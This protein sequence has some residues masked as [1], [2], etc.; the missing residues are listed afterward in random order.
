MKN[1][2]TKIF[3]FILFIIALLMGYNYF[4]RPFL[5]NSQQT[6][7]DEKDK[8]EMQEAINIYVDEKLSIFDQLSPEQKITQIMALPYNVADS[9]LEIEELNSY[10]SRFEAPSQSVDVAPTYEDTPKIKEDDL[11]QFDYRLNAT[12]SSQLK[13]FQ[14]GIITLFGEKVSLTDAKRHLQA[15][16]FEF[17]DQALKPLI[18]VD[19]EGGQVQRLSGEGFKIL[20]AWRLFCTKDQTQRLELLQDSAKQL[21]D[22]GVAIVF[23]PV[24]DLNSQVLGSRSCQDYQQAFDSAQDYISTFGLNGIMPVIKHFPGLGQTKQDLHLSSD[25]VDLAQ[26]DTQIFSKILNEYPN[27][28]IMT[29][30]LQLK[31]KLD[32]LPCSLSSECLSVFP[33]QFPLSLIF[34]DALEMKALDSWAEKLSESFEFLFLEED[35]R[36]T[37]A[38]KLAVLSYYAILAGNNVLVYGDKITIEQLIKVRSELAAHYLQ[39]EVFK[40]KVDLSVIKLLATKKI[41]NE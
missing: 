37:P 6:V 21:S 29:A 18:A 8:K 12:S 30:H 39:D 31:D 26:E 1:N 23:A 10:D 41:N 4:A 28:G 2:S 32:G 34:S 13:Q 17:N 27:I 22:L 33:E 19:H 36:D 20:P 40:K 24:L 9:E 5:R 14:P 3:I 25:E 35:E 7:Q 15:I 38:A 11:S 16:N